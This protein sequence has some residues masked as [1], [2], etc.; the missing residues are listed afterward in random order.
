MPGVSG[1]NLSMRLKTPAAVLSAGLLLL[2][3][4]AFLL[5]PSADGP[6]ADGGEAAAD[7]P[8]PTLPPSPAVSKEIVPPPP[9]PPE[10]A[11]E[12]RRV[13]P[14]PE[15]VH[16]VAG[17]AFLH[18]RFHPL[19]FATLSY[20]EVFDSGQS[21]WK[22]IKTDDRGRFSAAF[23]RGGDL[24]LSFR[25]LS[26]EPLTFDLKVSGSP[27]EDLE[28]IFTSGL[29]VTGTVK[30]REGTALPGA[31]LHW[32]RMGERKLP[33]WKCLTDE[34]GRYRQGGFEEGSYQVTIEG[35]AWRGRE[36]KVQLSGETHQQVDL[37]FDCQP[38]LLVQV[39]SEEGE[40]VS[41]LEVSYSYSIPG[42]GGTKSSEPT[43][44]DG[45]TSIHCIP[46]DATVTLKAGDEKRGTG[47]LRAAGPERDQPVV[48]RL[49]PWRTIAGT[50]IGQGGEPVPAAVV[51]INEFRRG[52]PPMKTDARGR[53]QCRLAVGE[54]LLEVNGDERGSGSLSVLVGAE[55]SLTDLRIQL[56][57]RQTVH[58][59]LTGAGGEPIEGAEL[60][61]SMLP[62]H[63]RHEGRSDA[64]GL[65]TLSLDA[66]VH[67]LL[68]YH[69]KYFPLGPVPFQVPGPDPAEIRLDPHHSRTI[70]GM[71]VDEDRPAPGARIYYFDLKDE[72]WREGGVA[73]AEGGFRIF[74]VIGERV[75]LCAF[76][77][78][79]GL[80][81]SEAIEVPHRGHVEGVRV[82]A[83]PGL[84]FE[85]PL[86]DPN[87]ASLSGLKVMLRTRKKPELGLQ[88]RTD[89][90]GVLKV[91]KLPPGD[92]LLVAERE[93]RF[94]RELPFHWDGTP[95]LNLEVGWEEK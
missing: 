12:E 49:E 88:A 93:E 91:R 38:P 65:L 56:E 76:G 23:F 81:S 80:A 17:R 36:T 13:A 87:G 8:A 29:L 89:R 1:E 69:Q 82:V 53:F 95:H 58:F 92:Y 94:S 27:Q 79:F 28:L 11:V 62:R 45:W 72:F 37:V 9:A 77:E 3:L 30:N 33:A 25:H 20:A 64:Q 59:R 14:P 16:S 63:I 22:K 41:G 24:T 39:L 75:Y 42:A 32:E 10:T 40:P 6:P 2:L 52:L 47:W 90:W 55:A 50:V 18:D 70:S 73:N 15:V 7:P 85:V 26:Y 54:Y 66:G 34:E 71:V 19:C 35:V 44:A 68:V 31:M 48:L 60:E 83:L 4:L 43:D 84:D 46:L 57:G 51:E 74:G 67:Q 78:G 21:D 61:L 86:T 5:P